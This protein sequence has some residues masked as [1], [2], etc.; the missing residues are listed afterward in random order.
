MPRGAAISFSTRFSG[1]ARRSSRRSGP[2]G[3]ATALRSTHFTLIPQFAGGRRSL[4]RA[5]SGMVR[6]R[7]L[8]IWKRRLR[9]SE[10]GNSERLRPE[11]V[12]YANPPE[13]TRFKKGQSGN[14]KGRPK[15]PTSQS[16]L[17]K[18][19]L[20]EKVTTIE[21][22]RRKI[23]TKGEAHYKQSVNKAAAGD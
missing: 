12:G 17:L 9:M 19:V 11:A 21:N 6:A 3:S 4:G 22:G 10:D 14:P 16:E 2:A 5:R 8:A 1:A 13:R 23:I 20:N 18:K 7:S 15:R